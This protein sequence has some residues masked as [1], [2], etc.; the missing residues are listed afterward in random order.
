MVDHIRAV[1]KAET[2]EA[3]IVLKMQK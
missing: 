3:R 2:P 1:A